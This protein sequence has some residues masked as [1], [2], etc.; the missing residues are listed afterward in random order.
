MKNED[1]SSALFF[2]MTY[3]FLEVYMPKQCGRS[4]HTV[5]WSRD[6]LTLS[7]GISSIRSASRSVSSLSLSVRGSAFLVSWIIFPDFTVDQHAQPTPCSVEVI[8]V[9]RRGRGHHAAI[10]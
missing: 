6:A 4:P 8:L 7:G 10:D 5:E 1:R 3:E 9:I 2:S